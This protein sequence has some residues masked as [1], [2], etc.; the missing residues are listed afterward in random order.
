[1]IE[2]AAS[3]TEP[4]VVLTGLPA[5]VAVDTADRLR[6]AGIPVLEGF[7]S[8]LLALRHLLDAVDRPA[9][10][11][12]QTRRDLPLLPAV[13]E[14]T[15]ATYGIGTPAVRSA[16]SLTEV[17]AAAA[18]LG[19]PVVLKTAAPGITHRSDVGGV[20]V[21]IADEDALQAAYADLDARLGPDVTVH[22][23]APPGVELSV[24]I[25][26]DPAL[27]PMVVVAAGGVLVELMADRVVA[28]PPVSRAGAMRMLDR[29]RLRPLLDGF[30]GAPAVDLDAL[31]D[32]VVAVSRLARDHGHRIDALDLNPV[33]ATPEGAVAVDVLII[34]STYE[35][36]T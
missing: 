5:A 31:A 28:L 21:G 9:P 23:Q 22:Q 4:V 20:V 8:G 6:A 17:V 19:F 34:P 15:L 3:T 35:E 13:T 36:T 10:D 11:P 26:R 2:V 29:L 18:D 7:R 30:R 12:V 1:M 24:G 16:S 33:L 14:Q 32:V 25:V 27:G